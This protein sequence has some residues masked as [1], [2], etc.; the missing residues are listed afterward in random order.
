MTPA[1]KTIALLAAVLIGINAWAYAGVD[2]TPAPPHPPKGSGIHFSVEAVFGPGT[3]A[4]HMNLI[5]ATAVELAL[6]GRHDARAPR[7]VRIAVLLV[8]SEGPAPECATRKG[9]GRLL[10]VTWL[11]REGPLGA[12]GRTLGSVGQV[13]CLALEAD[14][15]AEVVRYGVASAVLGI[16]KLVDDT[17]PAT[18]NERDV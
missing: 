7:K 5:E 8:Q 1:R 11:V 15:W 6:S 9:G 13:Q 4:Q 16:I 18:V 2:L 10:V 12:L 17:A 3:Q 14:V